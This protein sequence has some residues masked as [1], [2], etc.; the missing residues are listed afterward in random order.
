MYHFKRSKFNLKT[1]VGIAAVLFLFV[2][3][4]SALFAQNAVQQSSNAVNQNSGGAIVA[5]FGQELF[6]I[7]GNIGAITAQKRA[8]IV[9]DNIKELEKDPI[10][11]KELLTVTQDSSYNNYNIIYADKVI[12]S[13]DDNQAAA[14]GKSKEEIANEYM[15]II[16]TA[17]STQN[18]Y[19]KWIELAYRAG[20][21]LLIL[22]ITFFAFKFLNKFYNTLTQ[23]ALKELEK[24]PKILRK[25]MGIG[26]QVSFIKNAISLFRIVLIIL[27]IIIDF[28][29][30][31]SLFP[32]T[33]WIA[34]TIINY[35]ITPLKSFGISFW[36]YIPDLF[37]IIVIFAIYY[38][39]A[40]IIRIAAL[41][42][43]DGTIKVKNFHADWAMSTY[44]ILRAVLLIFTVIAIFPHLP[45]A[46]SDT[47]K[48]MSM[49]IGLLLSLGSAS[50]VNNIVS[51]LVITYMRAF[52]IGDRI[53]M[54]DNVGNVIEKTALVTRIRTAKNEII[55]VPN[56]NMMT[57]HTINY[58]A[59][60]NNVG[61]IL[62]Y[63]TAF[64]Y[65]VPWRK[66]HALLI[67]AAEKTEN[68]LKDPKPFVL[69]T[70]L[71]DFYVRYQINAYTD[72]ADTM[73]KTY[74]D[75]FQNIQDVFHRENL[76][77]SLPHL[78]Q[79]TLIK[80]DGEKG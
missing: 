31:L 67:E 80:K 78:Y 25:I 62:N 36:N 43:E 8:E 1:A 66:V 45:N 76:D 27:V 20:L 7:Y 29:L 79:N 11:T 24:L 6:T 48:G 70:A 9:S 16:L 51:G 35:I 21:V 15:Q 50:I 18:P 53:K 3:S 10:F 37:V 17:V 22:V 60:A 2:V 65:D 69:Q 32:E 12:F 44:N 54:G 58:T 57:A 39:A 71:D 61:L 28:M 47:F 56:S 33:R 40:K 5:P 55:T 23:S 42:I 26:R 19:K 64:G 4:H 14:L 30:I 74:S 75:L 49:F 73:P 52:Q 68:V 34:G 46:S 59:S 41:K 72:N 38:A 77:M 63:D 13:I